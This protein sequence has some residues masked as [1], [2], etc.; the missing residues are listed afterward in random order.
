MSKIPRSDKKY[1]DAV[2]TGIEWLIEYQKA[3]GGWPCSPYDEGDSK[4]TAMVLIDLLS[5]DFIRNGLLRNDVNY[6][7][8]LHS[9]N[10]VLNYMG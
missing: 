9:L 10:L 2:I 6:K 4:T 8:L 3:D 1:I 5:V 7:W